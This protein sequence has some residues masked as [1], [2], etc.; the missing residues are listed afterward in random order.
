MA[1]VLPVEMA[2]AV[3]LFAH[4]FAGVAAASAVSIGLA[5][6]AFGFWMG[7]ISGMAEASQRMFGPQDGKAA[8]GSSVAPKARSAATKARTA[9]KVLIEETQSAALEIA[10]DVVAKAEAS[11]VAKNAVELQPEDFR[12]PKSMSKPK[13]VDDLKAISGVGPKLEKVLNELG[14]WTYAQI[15]GWTTEETAWVDDYL[16]FTGRIERDDWIGQAAALAGRKKR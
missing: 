9:T 15:A 14:V 12:Q 5:S 3:N 6:Q 7:A 8:P 13:K 4:P 10:G 1:T 2:S 16:S 11:S